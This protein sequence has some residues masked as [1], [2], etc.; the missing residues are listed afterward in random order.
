MEKE[1]YDW[2]EFFQNQGIAAVVLKYRMP[3]GQPEVP[4]S[5]AEQAMSLIRLNATSW[6]INRNDAVSWASL[7]EATLP[8]PLLQ[9]VKVRLSQTSDSLLS[10]H[11]YDGRLRT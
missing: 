1:G 4:I 8:Q 7:Q 6:K 10:S 5:D 11:H 3:H 2:G 9:E